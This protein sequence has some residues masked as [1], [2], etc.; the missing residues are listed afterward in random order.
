MAE[1]NQFGEL[2]SSPVQSPSNPFTD[3]GSYA[4]PQAAAA[5]L[6]GL[7]GDVAAYRTPAQHWANLRAGMDPF[8]ERRAPMADFA[9][10]MMGRYYLGSPYLETAQQPNVSFADYLTGFAGQ[11]PART[12]ADLETLRER[13]RM[14]GLAGVTPAGAY[15]AGATTPEDFAIRGRY[16]EWFGPEAQQQAQNQ[17]AVAQ[18]LALQKAGGGTYRGR[19]ADAI[20]SALGRI[21]QR[22][23]ASGAPS[24]GFLNWY[25]NR[26]HP[27]ANTAE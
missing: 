20:R 26:Y 12:M 11:T 18:T 25:M 16:G 27:A 19:M 9:Q 14:A 15:E 7:A 3:W 13:A 24:G 10:R 8:W 17:L 4:S 21:Q 6:Q 2:I 5:G 23:V 1:Y 22:Q